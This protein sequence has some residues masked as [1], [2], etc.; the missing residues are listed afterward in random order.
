L[1]DQQRAEREAALLAAILN[2][3]RTEERLIE[4]AAAEGRTILRR[5]EADPRAVLGLRK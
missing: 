2:A 5:P 3:E 4:A 1:D